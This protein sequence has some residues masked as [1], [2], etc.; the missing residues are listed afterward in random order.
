MLDADPLPP[1]Y[2][3]D[4]CVAIAVDP[5]TLYVYWE[6]RDD[7]LAAMKQREGDGAL[8]LRVLV[9]VPTWDGPRTYTRDID[10][11]VQLGDWFVRELPKDA[12]VRAAIGWLSPQGA[13]LSA[14]HSLTA[15]PAPR[16][17]AAVFAESLAR[18]TPSGTIRSHRATPTRR[19]RAS[20]E[21]S[22]GARHAA[23]PRTASKAAARR[24]FPPDRVS[25]PSARASASSK[26]SRRADHP[27]TVSSQTAR[28]VAFGE[29]AMA[30]ILVVEDEADIRRGARRTT[31]AQA[32]HDA[33]AR[34]ARQGGARQARREPGPRVLDL[35][36]PDIRGIEVCKTIKHDP[37]T[38]HVPVLMLTARGE[39]IDRVVGFEVGADDYIV[40]PFSMR[41]LLAPGERRPPTL[42][43]RA[44]ES[45]GRHRIR[46]AARSIR[47][48]IACGSRVARSSSRRSSSAC[49]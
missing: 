45:A 3:V 42:A 38:E 9:I 22:R 44:G 35:M 21:R 41:E 25:S 5:A 2:D 17:R 18:W 34:G 20:L 11:R 15:Q 30:R 16:E 32:G 36:L 49:S 33:A 26:L 23:S 48:R 29:K 24:V 37:R 43:R 46:Q 4:E 12:I 8:T 40:K 27:F 28:S 19:P 10:A 39:E 1:K 7:T 13:F 47:K 14:A 31:S 6:V